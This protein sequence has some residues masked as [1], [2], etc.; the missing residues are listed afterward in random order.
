MLCREWLRL[1]WLTK[2]GVKCLPRPDKKMEWVFLRGRLAKE[3][4][5]MAEGL[6]FQGSL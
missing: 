6:Y 4:F 2:E 5:G 1:R 3:G